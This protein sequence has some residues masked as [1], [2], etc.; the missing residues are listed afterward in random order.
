[1]LGDDKSN[2]SDDKGNSDPFPKYQPLT[3]IFPDLSE[4]MASPD[5][6]KT[7]LK[8]LQVASPT[9]EYHK[10]LLS[11]LQAVDKTDMAHVTMLMDAVYWTFENYL[12]LEKN[13]KDL[14]NSGV[15]NS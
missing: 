3:N 4:I 7:G 8:L 11:L 10:D 6:K 14:K 9:P 1:N 2:P 15:K 12:N 13:I 5:T